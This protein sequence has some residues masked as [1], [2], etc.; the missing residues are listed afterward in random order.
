M[1]DAYG[2]IVNIAIVVVFLVLV[3]GY[4]AFNVNYTKAFR[5]KN[6]IISLLEEYEG[7]GYENIPGC[8][9]S[10]LCGDIRNYASQIGY[11]V[12][13]MNAP[14]DGNSWVC[15][16]SVGYCVALMGKG[17]NSDAVNESSDVYFTVITQININ[18][19]IINNIMGLRIFQVSGSTKTMKKVN[20]T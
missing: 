8:N 2:G 9:G 19:P 12:N 5:L 3:S 11:N 7:A 15:D 1:R 18:I 17:N 10:G 14:D 6:K 13:S 20:L 4:L 16:K